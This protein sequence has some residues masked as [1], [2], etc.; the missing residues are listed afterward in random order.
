MCP[1]V[2]KLVQVFLFLKISFS[3]RKDENF[4]G[5]KKKKKPKN[6]PILVL[7]TGPLMLSNML[8]PTFN[9][10]LDQFLTLGFFVLWLK[11]LFL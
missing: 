1:F 6:D 8:G 11:P 10:S 3:L 5:I 9:T 2:L 7:K 4:S